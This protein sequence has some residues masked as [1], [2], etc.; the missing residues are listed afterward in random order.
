MNVNCYHTNRYSNTFTFLCLFLCWCILPFQNIFSQNAD[1]QRYEYTDNGKEYYGCIP[2][3]T[4]GMLLKTYDKR[5]QTS[6]KNN[7]YTFI[8]YDTT[9]KILDS[10]DVVQPARKSAYLN[11]STKENVYNLAYQNSGIYNLS[12]IYGKTSKVEYYIGKFPKHTII[13][14][15]RAVGSYVYFLGY[16]KDLPILIGKNTTDNEMTFFKIIPLNKNRFSILS[17]E[18][19]EESGEVYIFT[20]DFMKNE[21]LIK[22]YVFKGKDKILE[23]MIQS[24]DPE[25]YISSA[26]ASKLSDGSYIIS[27]TYNNTK[28]NPMSSVGIFLMKTN[29]DGTTQQTKFINYLDITNF[30]SYLSE[31]QQ[32]RIEKKQERKQNQDKELEINYYM[33]PH[34]IIEKDGEYILVCEAYYPTYRQECQY[35]TTGMG[36]SMHCYQVF[37]GF[38]YTHF[39]L[40]GFNENADLLW[41]NSAPLHIDEKPYTVVKFLAVSQKKP[42]TQIVYSTWDNLFIYNYNEGDLLNQET[43]PFF[44]EEEK[45]LNSINKTRYWYGNT[46]ISYGMQRTKNKE[47]KEKREMFFVEKIK[48]STNNGT[49]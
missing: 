21:N 16:I 40:L 23:K 2:L 35:I 27:G 20:K 29:A 38:Q 18:V 41:S 13:N 4:N 10:I 45:V 14:T 43:I 37:D 26:Y 46:F 36:T 7:V 49:H 9:F 11:Y 42:N 25:K 39:F 31:K 44:K 3:D 22:F 1:I 6:K 24:P 28:K 33:A 17:F 19:N 32:D 5:K 15:M 30:T 8:K 12:V 34:N 48:I 47:D